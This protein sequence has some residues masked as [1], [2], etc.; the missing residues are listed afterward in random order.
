MRTAF[1]TGASRGI[2]RAYAVALAEAGNR[3]ALCYARDEDS[4]KETQRAVEKAGTDA[5]SIRADVG[6]R[7]SVNAAFDEIEA[8]WGP[9]EMLVNNAGI[10]RDGLVARMSDE[11]WDDVLRVNLTGAFHTIRRA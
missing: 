1:V 5:L 7:N 6:D 9:V 11:H 4:A 2:G 3:V 10:T 8:A